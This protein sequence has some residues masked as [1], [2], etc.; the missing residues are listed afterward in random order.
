MK[1][2]IIKLLLF[3]VVLGSLLF[4]IDPYFLDN[5]QGSVSSY[6]SLYAADKNSADIVFLGNSHL[7]KGIDTYIIDAKCG[8]NSIKVCTGGIHIAQIYFNLLEVLDTQSP[9]LI[10]LELWPIIEPD[11][12]FNTIFDKNGKLLSYPFKG[13]YYKRFGKH[14]FNEIRLTHPE[15]KLYNMFNFFRFHENWTSLD[16]VSKSLQHKFSYSPKKVN[17]NSNKVLWYLP[18]SKVAE[19]ESTEFKIDKIYLSKQE[20]IYLNKIIDLSNKHD[21]KLLL[22]NVPI[23]KKYY[24]KTKTGIEN[25]MN[26]VQEIADKNDNVFVYN[27]NKEI[28]GFD[29]SHIM[30][31][32]V[33]KNQHLNYKGIIKT[34]N[35]VANFINKMNIKE[36][37]KN[38]NSVSTIENIIYNAKK[39]PMNPNYLGNVLK[40][41]NRKFTESENKQELVVYKNE[42]KILVE[43]WMFKKGINLNRS[44]KYLVLKKASEFVFVSGKELVDRRDNNVIERYGDNFEKSGYHFELDKVFLDKGKYRLYH[45][46]ESHDNELHIQDMWKWVIV[47]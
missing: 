31:E 33:S 17:Y 39:I 7:A 42:P 15:N 25:V 38:S 3:S 8:T 4:Y 47:K 44:K 24:N 5:S 29:F 6:N 27:I 30:G 2:L 34:S 12:I 16:T 41:N 10:A 36:D 46:I 45:V 14:K 9:S 37:K 18:K 11:N 23:Y 26:K 22:F 1:S 40:V 32:K 20:E 28:G 13:E 43:G 19:F 35:Y 21:F